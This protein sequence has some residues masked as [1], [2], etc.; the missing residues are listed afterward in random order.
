MDLCRDRR[1]TVGEFNRVGFDPL[2]C[3]IT[4]IDITPAVIN[5]HV[6]ISC[7]FESESGDVICRS[8]DFGFVD[9]TTISIPRVPTQSREFSSET[10][11]T[12]SAKINTSA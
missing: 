2:S 4:T 1:D 6:N 12:C 8:E 3:S 9:I 11:G 10:T 7:G 5:V